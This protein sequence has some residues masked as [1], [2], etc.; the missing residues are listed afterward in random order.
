MSSNLVQNVSMLHTYHGRRGDLPVAVAVYR[1]MI[2][3][4]VVIVKS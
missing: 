3:M 1:V 4:I 2:V